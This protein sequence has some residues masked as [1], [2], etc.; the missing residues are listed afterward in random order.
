MS[1]WFLLASFLSYQLLSRRSCSRISP[2]ALWKREFPLELEYSFQHNPCLAAKGSC[3]SPLCQ[4]GK[5]NTLGACRLHMDF[6]RSMHY[7]GNQVGT[8]HRNLQVQNKSVTQSNRYT[9]LSYS[10]YQVMKVAQLSK[11]TIGWGENC[12]HTTCTNCVVTLK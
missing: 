12:T 3:L 9:W 4:A 7:D 11:L 10:C 2:S 8:E 6:T 5:G 1:Q